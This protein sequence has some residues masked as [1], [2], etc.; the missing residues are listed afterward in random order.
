MHV[1]HQIE[2]QQARLI[3]DGS[4]KMFRAGKRKSENAVHR[5]AAILFAAD[6]L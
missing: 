3:A 6:Q 1:R 5:K 4:S 2:G